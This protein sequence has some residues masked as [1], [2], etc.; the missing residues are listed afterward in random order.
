VEH[1]RPSTVS[2]DE[3][4]RWRDRLSLRLF[5]QGMSRQQARQHV[6]ALENELRALTEALAETYHSPHLGNWQDPTDELVYIILS[7]KTIEK[8]YQQAFEVLRKIGDWNLVADMDVRSIERLIYGCGLE[9]KKA[10]AIKAGLQAAITL[11]GSADLRPAAS[12]DDEALFK[13]LAD[14]PEVGPKSARCIMLYSF[15]RAT[16]PV[17]AHVGRVL[18]RLGTFRL[19][20]IDLA[21]LNHKRQQALLADLVPPDLRY[22]LRVNLIAHGRAVCRAGVALCERCPISDRCESAFE[23]FVAW[24]T[25]KVSSHDRD[26]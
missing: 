16:F 12:M 2:D 1:S 18:S 10:V 26:G 5:G 21:G 19:L 6:V 8:A 7:R 4:A 15:G 17:D 24:D 3:V 13:L 25:P 23:R 14:L 22:L 9:A 11:F 20:G